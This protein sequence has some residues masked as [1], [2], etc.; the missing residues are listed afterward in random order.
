LKPNFFKLNQRIGAFMKRALLVFALGLNTFSFGATA[1]SVRDRVFDFLQNKVAGRTQVMDTEGT[2]TSDGAEYLVQFQASI[3]WGGLRKT[4][5]GLVFEETRDIKQSS[6][7]LDA[8]GKPVG[9]P[10]KADRTIVHQ[11]ALSE[12]ATTGS[13]VGIA[14]VTKNTLEDPTGQGF[15]TMIEL[16]ADDKELYL[17]G[18][19]AG[20]TEA[21]LD[22]KNI[23]PVAN[24][25]EATL[26]QDKH[27]KL[28]LNETLKFYKVN[29][30]KDFSRDEIHRFTLSASE[31]K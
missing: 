7:K 21:S 6:T 3:N 30:N 27:G 17:Y 9:A 14:T 8:Q 12:R 20:F 10:V 22:G 23:I 25:F 26:F 15:V 2:L 5:E 18:S 31:P 13:L 1:P 29:V 16:S 19:T 28:Q 4:A 11:Y 24:A